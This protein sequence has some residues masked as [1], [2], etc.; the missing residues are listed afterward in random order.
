MHY[1][2]ERA[3]CSATVDPTFRSGPRATAR[4][5]T[6]GSAILHPARH[7][8]AFLVN[9]LR[10]A[11]RR[12]RAALPAAEIQR[13]SLAVA[14]HLRGL[15]ALSRARR[16]ACYLA[17]HGE[18]DCAP[19]MAELLARGRHI[20]LPVLHGRSLLF[21][22]WDP[23]G[24]MVANRFGIPEPDAGGVSAARLDV[25]LAPLVAFDDAGRRLGMGGGF[26][27][28]ALRFLAQRGCWRR[29]LV[30]GL[31][32]EFQR[33]GALPARRWDVPLHA[34]V[35]ESGARFF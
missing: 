7:G 9:D 34:V 15:P 4:Y 21:A 13:L 18:V 12:R 31:G 17:M 11:L 20:Y 14:R 33:V 1:R 3:A 28:R 35:T 24:V 2:L 6:G 27:D 32:Y 8:S 16:I 25:V 29:P 26:Y 23:R 10:V 22:P 19:I 5:G 30:V